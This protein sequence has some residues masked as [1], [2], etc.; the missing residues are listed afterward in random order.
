VLPAHASHILLTR[1][2]L[3]RCYALQEHVDYYSVQALLFEHT[4]TK[5]PRSL[6]Q[7]TRLFFSY[8]SRLSD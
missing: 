2:A 6:L 8:R 3:R 1:N 7:T 4:A 5:A